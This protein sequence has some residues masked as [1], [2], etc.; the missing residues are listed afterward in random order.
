MRRVAIIIQP[1]RL[2]E[3][4][5]SLLSRT[6]VASS[7]NRRTA[8]VYLSLLYLVVSAL[9]ACS[10]PGAAGGLGGH[11]CDDL[12]GWMGAQ[13]AEQLADAVNVC[14]L[15]GERV[16]EHD[17]VDKHR[18]GE[19]SGVVRCGG[20]SGD[21]VADRL[22]G[23]V[24]GRDVDLD[25]VGGDPEPAAARCARWSGVRPQAACQATPPG[26]RW[27]SLREPSDPTCWQA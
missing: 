11:R 1:P 13:G 17:L 4:V 7:D 20:E 18:V 26:T 8:L 16:A 6:V 19:R 21:A 5:P 3:A 25:R 2:L 9:Q 15:A 10:A 12:L 22:V 23:Q 14:R 24:V 27:V